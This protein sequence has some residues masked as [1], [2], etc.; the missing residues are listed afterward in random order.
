MEKAMEHFKGKHTIEKDG[1]A[2]NVDIWPDDYPFE[3]REDGRYI[4]G[5]C[6]AEN[7]TI[8]GYDFHSETSL[9]GSQNYS[10]YPGTGG[11]FKLIK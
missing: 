10:L 9:R 8:T 11:W 1:K 2:R 6:S 4:N 5:F 7:C 3:D